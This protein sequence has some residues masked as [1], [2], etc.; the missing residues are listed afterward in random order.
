VPAAAKDSPGH[1]QEEGWMTGKALLCYYLI[2]QM[3]KSY[4]SSKWRLI[5]FGAVL[6]LSSILFT[7]CSAEEVTKNL[8]QATQAAQ[9]KGEELKASLNQR[10]G[11]A[12]AEAEKRFNEE[13]NKLVD[14]Y[15]DNLGNSIKSGTKLDLKQDK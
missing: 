5:L 3:L 8:E 15:L 12:A 9:Q 13:K 6:V 1:G 14:E 10:I 7:A 4:M 2:V 11:E